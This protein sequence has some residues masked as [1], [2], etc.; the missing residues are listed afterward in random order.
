MEA[1]DK[2]PE[3]WKKNP[4]RYSHR[5]QLMLLAFFG[6]VIAVYLGLY[7]LHIFASVWEPLFGSGSNQ[8]LHSSLAK[9]LPIPDSFIGAISYFFDITLC[10]IGS[11]LRWK[12][13]P[14]VTITLGAG[15][16]VF[17]L[18]SLALIIIQAFVVH[19]FCTLCLGSAF[20]SF[21][22]VWP[23]TLEMRA[24]LQYLKVLKQ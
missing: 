9:K 14:W 16:A 5:L 12:T 3:G 19:A 2:I 7:Q 11:E 10:I 1:T 17:A 21:A 22:L 6:F 13:K 15:A 20:I 18:S 23:A 8:V 4:S 24:T